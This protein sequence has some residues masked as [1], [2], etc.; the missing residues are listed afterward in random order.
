MK[1]EKKNKYLKGIGSAHSKIILMGE[2]SVVYGYS[3]LA[4]PIHNIR[5]KCTVFSEERNEKL[6]KLDIKRKDTLSVALTSALKYL[7][8][9]KDKLYFKIES[10]IP[11]KR[12]MGSSAAVSIA[13][14][15][16]IFN[17]YNK[18]LEKKTLE[19]LVNE[20]EKIAH[21]NPS[22]LDAKTCL[23][24]RAIKFIKN[25]GFY[26][27][28]LDLGCYLV[29]ADTGIH[30]NT[31]EAVD[32]IKN[33]LEKDKKNNIY[34]EKLGDLAKKVEKNIKEKDVVNIGKNMTL[35]HENLKKLGVSIKEADDLVE[36]VINNGAFGA[37]MS[38]GGLGG[39]IIALVEK[40]EEKI[41]K[42]EES[43]KEKGA[44]NVWI[45]TI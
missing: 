11:A 8:K 24:N 41:K 20:A 7:G 45:E 13:G 37:K 26:E 39:C 10:D 16:A 28:K 30:G 32:T 19:Y 6:F 18:K 33:K 14:I 35:A 2:H 12:G 22:G 1:Y 31:K 23:S 43:L 34:L 17:Y 5:A 4:I 38:G 21:G 36:T 27:I 3:A 25:V 15:R 29:I 40:N 42:I 9:E 44:I